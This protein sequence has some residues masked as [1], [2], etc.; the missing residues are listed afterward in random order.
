MQ[1]SLGQVVYQICSHWCWS[2]KANNKKTAIMKRFIIKYVLASPRQD[3]T[4]EDRKLKPTC[5]FPTFSIIHFQHLSAADEWT[6]GQSSLELDMTWPVQVSFSFA[7]LLCFCVCLLQFS[8]AA[9]NLASLPAFQLTGK[10]SPALLDPVVK[11]NRRH[12]HVGIF[13]TGKKRRRDRPNIC[14][15]LYDRTCLP[16]YPPTHKST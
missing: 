3:K 7:F 1:L 16:V 4:R 9:R 8:C 2:W 15:Y 6:D 13:I 12:K 10:F 11:R 14:I 5:I